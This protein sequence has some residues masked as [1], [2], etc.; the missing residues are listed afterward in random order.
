MS[1]QNVEVVRKAIEARNRDL[2]EWT[3]FFDPGVRSSDALIAVG[4]RTETQ[5]IDELRRHAEKWGEAFDEFRE[6][7]V[8]LVDLGELVLAE[9]RFH[10][11]GEASGA[12]VTASQVDFYRV[13]DGLITEYRSGYRSRQEAL[14]AAGL[15][16]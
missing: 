3:A 8:D 14:E 16:E 15:R 4:M 12:R 9:I 13:R 5:G 10:G 6:E 7:I 2:D 1:K 11:H